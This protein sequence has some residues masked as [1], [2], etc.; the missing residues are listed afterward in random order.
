MRR[1]V[2]SLKFSR[3]WANGGGGR[4]VY[5]RLLIPKAEAKINCE[6]VSAEKF[7]AER[8]TFEEQMTALRRQ[9]KKVDPSVS[10]RYLSGR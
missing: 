6:M 10:T 8:T 1:N 2:L 4:E 9:H 3:L 7:A 5:S